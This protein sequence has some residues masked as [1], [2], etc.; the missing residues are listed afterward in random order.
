[1]TELANTKP[2]KLGVNIEWVQKNCGWD[3]RQIYYEGTRR[4]RRHLGHLGKGRWQALQQQYSGAALVEALCAWLKDLSEP[5]A[6]TVLCPKGCQR[7]LHH[8]QC[9]LRHK[10]GAIINGQF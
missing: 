10:Q 2:P 1:M 3:C 7:P 8:G 5:S 9:S 6:T 4:R